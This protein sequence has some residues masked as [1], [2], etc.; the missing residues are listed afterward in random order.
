MGFVELEA[1]GGL[2]LDSIFL[3]VGLEKAEGGLL[4]VVVLGLLFFPCFPS[5]F[6]FFFGEIPKLSTFRK[7]IE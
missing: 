7:K 4:G 5:S 1:A 6:P 3:L 2:S